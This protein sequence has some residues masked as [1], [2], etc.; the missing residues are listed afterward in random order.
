MCSLSFENN[1]QSSELGLKT[2]DRVCE[3]WVLSV[4]LYNTETWFLIR[5]DEPRLGW[6]GEEFSESAYGTDGEMKISRLG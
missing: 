2:K 6:F 3:T 1:R 4:L 5:N